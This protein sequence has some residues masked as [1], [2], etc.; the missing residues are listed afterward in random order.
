M[1]V[2]LLQYGQYDVE[3]N[4]IHNSIMDILNWLLFVVLFL[5]LHEVQG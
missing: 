4:P 3:N 1:F 5:S 2:K